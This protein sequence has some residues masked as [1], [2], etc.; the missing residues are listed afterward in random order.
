MN[1]NN[2]CV[3]DKKNGVLIVIGKVN[4][5]VEITTFRTKKI[6]EK[7]SDVIQIQNVDQS[8]T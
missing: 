4:L 2:V 5:I 3:W 7:K 1:L 8:T 6:I